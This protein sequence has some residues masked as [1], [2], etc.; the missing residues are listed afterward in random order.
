MENKELIYDI[1][2][3]VDLGNAFGEVRR[4]EEIINDTLATSG[5]QERYKIRGNL[6][7]AKLSCGREPSK[8]ELAE[9]K[10]IILSEFNQH[11]PFS[12]WNVQ[13]ESMELRSQSG[14]SRNQSAATE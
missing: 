13:I 2:F 1:I 5:I 12:K 4:L 11:E 14:N 3:S 6:F 9:M 7:N 8:Q 10:K